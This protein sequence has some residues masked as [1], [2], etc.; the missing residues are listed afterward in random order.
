L[1][2]KKQEIFEG[3]PL[4][5]EGIP[6]YTVQQPFV[7]NILPRIIAT[8][9]RSNPKHIY[10]FQPILCDKPYMSKHTSAQPMSAVPSKKAS[11]QEFV[12]PVTSADYKIGGKIGQGAFAT[13]FV[14]QCIPNDAKVAIKVIELEPD[15][16][17]E[18][19]IKDDNLREIQVLYIY[20][21]MC[22]VYPPPIN[23]P[24]FR[25]FC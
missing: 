17:S 4:F 20:M 15:A 24:F 11:V 9:P 8:I 25:V 12:Y 3:N 2:Q 22:R 13:V 7:I 21:C 19:E 18:D 1:R 16:Q 10:P 23:P 14:A 6:E 5:Q